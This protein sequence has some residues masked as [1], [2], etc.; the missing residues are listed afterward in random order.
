MADLLVTM[1]DVE[2]FGVYRR[3]S[4]L[5]NLEDLHDRLHMIEPGVSSTET[6]ERAFVKGKL[7]LIDCDLLDAFSVNKLVGSVKPQR[8]F[9]LAAQSHVPTSWNAPV[10]TLEDNIIGQ[11]NLFEGIRSAG[12]D[13]LVQ[14]AGSSE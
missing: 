2:V 13:P 14:I 5:D 1:P 12:I 6:I 11:V 7:N 10:A 3:R 8:I 4:R 9:H